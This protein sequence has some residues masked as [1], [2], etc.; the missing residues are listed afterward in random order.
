MTSTFV[1]HDVRFM[2]IVSKTNKKIGKIDIIQR[3]YLHE[4]EHSNSMDDPM[5]SFVVFEGQ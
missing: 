3:F 5:I 2:N 4:L 1:N